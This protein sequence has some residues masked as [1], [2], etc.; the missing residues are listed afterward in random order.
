MDERN[1]HP[2][3]RLLGSGLVQQTD[4]AGTTD[5]DP[6][7]WATY[8]TASGHEVKAVR[9]PNPFYVSGDLCRD[10]WLVHDERGIKAVGN[11]TFC[12]GYQQ[13]LTLDEAA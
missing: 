11:A 1:D 8:A 6:D 9:I 2:R 4:A 10:G 12:R 7:D 5:F 13:P 3:F